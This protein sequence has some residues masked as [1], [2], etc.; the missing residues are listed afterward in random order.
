MV[1]IK[2][3]GFMQQQIDN[4]FIMVVGLILALFIGKRKRK[5]NEN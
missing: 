2:G 3:P 1:D 5:K 4:Y